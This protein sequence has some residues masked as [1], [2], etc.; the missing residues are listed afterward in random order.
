MAAAPATVS[1]GDFNA[2]GQMAGS[3]LIGAKIHNDKATVGSIDDV[4]LD[5]SGNVKVIVVSVGGFLGVGGKNR[6]GEMGRPQVR[7][8]RQGIGGDDHPDRGTR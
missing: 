3:A 8:G 2:S 4:Y 5:D 1:T 7:Q 6:R